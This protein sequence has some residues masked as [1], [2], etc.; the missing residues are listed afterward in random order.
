MP[1]QL[2]DYGGG[3]GKVVESVPVLQPETRLALSAY[4]ITPSTNA[5]SPAV[6]AVYV[7]QACT[8]TM[9]GANGAS[10]TFTMDGAGIPPMVPVKGT[11]ISTGTVI[12]LHDGVS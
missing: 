4:A 11:A 12:G 9:T 6:K 3:G 2:P 7:N 10:A 1:D 5:L 8:I